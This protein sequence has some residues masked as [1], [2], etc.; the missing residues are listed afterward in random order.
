LLSF[1]ESTPPNKMLLD[2]IYLNSLLDESKIKSARKND[3]NNLTFV[4]LIFNYLV[5]LNYECQSSL[6]HWSL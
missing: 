5:R 1:T 6:T 4:G 3:V 2:Y